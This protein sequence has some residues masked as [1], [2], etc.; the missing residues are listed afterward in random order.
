MLVM[1][2]IDGG[3]QEREVKLPGWV[4][5]GVDVTV[6]NVARMYDYVLG[7]Y[8]NFAVDR[9]YAEKLEQAFPGLREGAYAARA[10]LSRVVR[11]LVDAGI[12][13]F[14]DIGSGIPTVG[15]VHEIAERAA[16]EVR[17]MYVDID[18]IAVAHTRAI[19]AG[20]PR[21]RVLQADPRRPVDI[22]DHPDVTDLL[23]FSEPVAVMLMSV[24]HFIPDADD[25]ERIVGQ[26][27]DAVVAGSYIALS[28]AVHVTE[29]AEAFEAVRQVSQRTPTPWHLRSQEQVARLLTG[30]D[31][32]EPGIVTLAEWHPNLSEGPSQPWPGHLVAVGRKP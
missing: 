22:V 29:R 10:L 21:V 6:P 20:H 15:N 30:L 9:E 1:S 27:R 17:V 5:E 7:G 25:P 12:R 4:P 16:P 14:L 26:L 28:H 13:Q 11:W 31:L 24:L 19:L 18:P 2:G 3:A 32:V 8:H 23:D